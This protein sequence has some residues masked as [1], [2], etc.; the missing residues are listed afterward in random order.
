[1]GK[2]ESRIINSSSPP[3]LVNSETFKDV[4]TPISELVILKAAFTHQRVDLLSKMAINTP[5]RPQMSMV[6]LI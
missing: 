5:T 6:K 3:D 1:M 4:D 2:M